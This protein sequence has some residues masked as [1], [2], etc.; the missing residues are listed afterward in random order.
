MCGETTQEEID[1]INAHLAV[2]GSL[3][4]AY[5]SRRVYPYYTI[6]IPKH[7]LRIVAAVPYQPPSP[8]RSIEGLKHR[9]CCL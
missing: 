7:R 6:F 9:W 2:K 5:S 8:I 4:S 3:K 1:I